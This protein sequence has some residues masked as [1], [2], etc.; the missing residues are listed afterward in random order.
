LDRRAWWSGV[1]H[2]VAAH[3]RDEVM[4][5]IQEAAGE[6]SGGIIGVGHHRN[7][8]LPIQPQEQLSQLVEQGASI[9]VGPDRAFVNA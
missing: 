8:F 1:G 5:M 9:P 2:S 7:G 3:R 6:T 4:A